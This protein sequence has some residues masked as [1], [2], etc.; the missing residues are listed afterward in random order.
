MPLK[1]YLPSTESKPILISF[2]NGII[3]QG[4]PTIQDVQI[5][6]PDLATTVIGLKDTYLDVQSNSR[7]RNKCLIEMQVL[8]VKAFENELPTMQPKLMQIN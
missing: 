6:D 1:K 2:L 4:N 8:N 3:Y 5:I 7:Q